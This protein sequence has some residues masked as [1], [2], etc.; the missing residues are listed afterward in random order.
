MGV[1]QSHEK[2]SAVVRQ[3]AAAGFG[4]G[5]VHLLRS[6][7]NDVPETI[8]VSVHVETGAEEARARIILR[9]CGGEAVGTAGASPSLLHA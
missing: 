4:L 5:D 6:R 3:L 2:A 1:F 9:R 7:S 8:L